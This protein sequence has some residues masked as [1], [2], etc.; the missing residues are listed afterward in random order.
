MDRGG[1]GKGQSDIHNL[2]E[3]QAANN[4]PDNQAN[5]DHESS[6]DVYRIGTT[7]PENSFSQKAGIRA[8]CNAPINVNPQG[9]GG[10]A[11]VGYL[12]INCIPGD[13]DQH[14]GPKLGQFEPNDFY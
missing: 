2:P 11:Y 4:K 12:I 14:F 6:D 3:K 8:W 13:F 5:C 10:R 1:G 7:M 9:G